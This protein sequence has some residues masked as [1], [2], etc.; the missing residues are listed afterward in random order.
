MKICFI[1][2]YYPP[3]RLG[4]V[5][6]SA[7]Y[8]KE[9]LENDG[10]EIV[11]LTAGRKSEDLELERN[12]IRISS[13]L[14]V[15]PFALFLLF[16]FLLKRYKFDII[17]F[18]HTIAVTV[19]FWKYIYQKSFPA[20]VF[21]FK[22]SRFHIGKS[23]KNVTIQGK[24]LARPNFSELRKK[25]TFFILGKLVDKFF[26]R[27]CNYLTAN[28]NDTREK[29]IQNYNIQPDK[30][31]TIHNGV[32]TQIFHPDIDGKTIRKK[33]GLDKEILMLFVGGFSILKRIPLLL[34]FM[35]K[36]KKSN[37]NL[38]LMITGKG[39]GYDV[40]LKKLAS[41]LGVSGD[42]IFTGLIKNSQ[43]PLYYA[44]SDMLIVPSEY[45]SFGIINIEAMAMAKPIIA[46]DIGGIKDIIEDGVTGFLVEKDDHDRFLERISFLAEDEATRQQMGQKALE[47]IRQYFDWD[48]IRKKYIC[49]YRKTLKRKFEENSPGNAHKYR[50]FNIIAEIF[51]D[52]FSGFLPLKPD[53]LFLVITR[54]CNARCRMCHI[55]TDK[56]V[57]D[58]EAG[59]WNEII[60]S[61]KEFLSGINKIDITGG[62]P[63]LRKDLNYI[64]PTIIKELPSLRKILIASN[65]FLTQ[66]IEQRI[67]GLLEMT[68]LKR[69]EVSITISLDGVGTIHD[70]IRGVPEAFGKAAETLRCLCKMREVNKRLHVSVTTVMQPLNI[71]QL[72]DINNY[73]KSEYEIDDHLFIPASYS[74]NFQKNL[75]ANIDYNQDQKDKIK[76]FLKER[77][78]DKATNPYHRVVYLDIIASLK[79]KQQHR[80]CPF[81]RRSVVIDNNGNVMPCFASAGDVYGTTSSDL[82]DLWN[83]E[84][85]KFCI[86]EYEKK[87]CPQCD[88]IC[89]VGYWSIIKNEIKR[90]LWRRCDQ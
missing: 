73:V 20:T 39:R 26:A 71:E 77:I 72:R 61:N 62:E 16:P 66:K 78:Q 7:K 81:L 70:K 59:E 83:G 47:R 23:I 69:Q 14:S 76:D 10:H 46:S 33:Y 75:D 65:G 8:L 11:V 27:A 54:R 44:A 30:I 74:E 49:A 80:R 35:S 87:R 86:Q 85:R 57:R 84:K 32:N 2:D 37:R 90:H 38:K 36:L 88:F 6:E 82:R 28:S 48:D 19:L 3:N 50:I 4:G 68:E 52:S 51:R 56:E 40:N 41:K 25:C 63:F 43:I 29:N 31:V 24:I 18:H 9:A 89:G 53:R 5:G 21:T 60:S 42:T 34:Y 15:F 1:V 64:L 58:L 67:A 12:V 22:C 55:W 79:G 45:E 13:R 17:H